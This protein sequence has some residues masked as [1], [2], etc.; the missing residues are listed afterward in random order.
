VRTY[1]PYAPSTLYAPDYVDQW[2]SFGQPEDFN[3]F[4]AQLTFQRGA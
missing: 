2:L 1:L 3:N 4:L